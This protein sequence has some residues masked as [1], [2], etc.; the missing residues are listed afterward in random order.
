MEREKNLEVTRARNRE[1]ERT[2]RAG[3]NERAKRWR[4]AHPE[5]VRER[6]ALWHTRRKGAFIEHVLP[7]VV[8]ERADGVCGV[9]GEDVDPAS[10]DIDHIVPLSLGGLHNYENTQPAHPICNRR[11]G[12]QI[13]VA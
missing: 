13:L 1:Y 9:C 6:V 12:A 3:A 2:H 11:K 10:F 8:L 4:Q 5:E 7:L